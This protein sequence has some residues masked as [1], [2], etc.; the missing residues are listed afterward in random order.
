M[1]VGKKPNGKCQM[2][3]TNLERF[4]TDRN[5]EIARQETQGNSA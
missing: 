4:A 3:T 1:V 2:N 5:K